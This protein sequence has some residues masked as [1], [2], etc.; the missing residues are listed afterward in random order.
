M[1]RCIDPLEITF[2]EYRAI[3]GNSDEEDT[4]DIVYS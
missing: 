4:K 2:N 3:F 1:V